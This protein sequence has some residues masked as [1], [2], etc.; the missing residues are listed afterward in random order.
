MKPSGCLFLT[1]LILLYA[2]VYVDCPDCYKDQQPLD[3]ARGL[4]PT[5][6]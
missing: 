2:A 1:L 4:R 5:A 3:P 6:G